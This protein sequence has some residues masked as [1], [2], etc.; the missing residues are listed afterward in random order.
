MIAEVLLYSALAVGQLQLAVNPT[1][2]EHSVEQCVWT[3]SKSTLLPGDPR[4]QR[5][6]EGLQKQSGNGELQELADRQLARAA[7]VPVSIVLEVLRCG[8]DVAPEK[9]D[10]AILADAK[11]SVGEIVSIPGMVAP[12]GSTLG[13]NFCENSIQTSVTF[14]RIGGRWVVTKV[15]TELLVAG[16]PPV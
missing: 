10:N 12:N 1:E 9:T 2:D 4:L 3:E 15:E 8:D 13:L 14:T 6:V 16:C 5:L 11:Y 7:K